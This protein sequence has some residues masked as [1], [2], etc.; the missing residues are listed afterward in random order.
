MKNIKT[1]KKECDPD[2]TRRENKQRHGRSSFWMH[3]PNLI[4]SELKLKAGDYFLDMGCG[5][6]DYAIWASKI[7]GNSGIVYALDR[8]QDLIDDLTKKADLEELTNI[9]GM[10]TDITKPLSIDEGYI[11]VYFIS[12]VL[13]SLDLVK[14][15][16]I[17]F[18]EIYRVLKPDGRLAIIEC[19]KEELSFGP[20]L[21][22][23]L[24]PEELEDLITK[25]GF[26]KIKLTDLGYNY[27][28][29]FKKSYQ[30]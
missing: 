10:V 9:V 17:I 15:S 3:D 8:W 21:H 13:H 16:N 18:S 23:R 14:D 11:N 29:Q 28:I 24:S 2:P 5:P 7:V 30:K 27:M 19:K 12:T 22:M 25:Y 20:P 4:F 1:C 26:E 6:G